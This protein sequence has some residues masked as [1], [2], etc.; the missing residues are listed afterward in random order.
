MLKGNPDWN[1]ARF[2]YTTNRHITFAYCQLPLF[3]CPDLTIDPE[4]DA[5][6]NRLYE[7]VS[8]SI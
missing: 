3:H 4:D 1:E 5:L 2:E 6:R 7:E 8:R